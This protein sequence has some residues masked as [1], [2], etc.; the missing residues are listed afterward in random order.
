MKFLRLLG[1]VN[2]L[3]LVSSLFLP[4]IV[5]RAPFIGEYRVSMVDMMLNRIRGY[6]GD[7]V[8]DGEGFKPSPLLSTSLIVT[9]LLLIGSF[10]TSLLTL[11]R[12]K[13]S[14]FAGILQISTYIMWN[15][16][17]EIL[18]NDLAS[19]TNET[20]IKNLIGDLIDLGLGVY[21]VLIG[22]IIGLAIYFLG[23]Y[24]LKDRQ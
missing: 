19:S 20:F 1:I 13:T 21:L 5:L 14:I 23:R 16:S 22:G 24:M 11:W 12:W 18:K 3:I 2:V 6:P 15:I 17:V 7:D 10:L 9:I 8:K 4:W